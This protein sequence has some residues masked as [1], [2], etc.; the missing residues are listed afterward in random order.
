MKKHI[1]AN[2]TFVSFSEKNATRRA[3][4]YHKYF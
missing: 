2:A 3:G 4:Q 1:I